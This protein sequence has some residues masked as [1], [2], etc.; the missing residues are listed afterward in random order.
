MILDFL[1]NIL[2]K[3]PKKYVS[4]SWIEHGMDFDVGVYGSNLKLCC[5]LSHK[6][7]G[8]AYIKKDYYG[9]KIDWKDF[10]KIRNK[11][12]KIQQKG[13]T[14]PECEG[15]VFLKEGYWDQ[16]NYIDSIIFDHFTK[17]NCNCIYC[18][19]TESKKD[20]NALK[21]YNVLPTIKE[22]IKKDILKPGG[23]I[24]F[25]GGEPTILEEF[26]DLVSLLL[27]KGFTNIRVPSSGIKYSEIIEKGI[28]KGQLFVVVS[29]DSGTKETYK[30]IKR[31][32]KYEIVTENLKRYSKAQPSPGFVISKYILI[33]NINDTK[34]EIDSWLNF[35]KENNI[36]S[37]VIDIENSWLE[38][39]MEPEYKYIFE[40]ISYVKEKSEEMGFVR[41]DICD[42]A[43]TVIKEMKSQN[44]L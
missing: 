13:K 1:K 16:E 22:M 14:I 31:T 38:K 35:N 3:K 25:G 11:Y 18:Y 2:K 6:G 27:D 32:D 42:R 30:K 43:A 28:S 7:K 5:Y 4:C 39:V 19:T 41:C 21:S 26:E 20:Y 44:L 40:L 29:I 24:G 10:F 15:C 8:N 33:P 34:E 36:L 37:I 17:C 23:A 12:R 9:E